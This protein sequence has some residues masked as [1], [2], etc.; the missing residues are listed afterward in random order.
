[1]PELPEVEV[2]RRSLEPRLVGHRIQRLEVLNRALR[3][4]VRPSD[5]RR[6]AVR[7]RIDAVG[8]RSKYL[9][10]ALERGATLVFHLGMSGRITLAGGGTP[11]ELHEHLRF[12]LDD[13][14]LL[15]FRDP[16]RFGLAFAL[17]S[18]QLAGD[19]HFATLGPEPLTDA[20][21]G[22]TLEAAA[23]RR[24]GPVKG[25]LMDAR[26]VVG[27]GNIYAC[28]ALHHSGIHPRRS[29]ARI[30]RSRWK[31]LAEAVKAVLARAIEEGGTTL[32]DFT[33][34]DG[35]SGYFQ[36][37]LAVYGRDGKA[38]ARCGRVIKRLVQGGRGTF[39]CPGCQR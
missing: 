10:I 6:L 15:R 8:R 33:D 5:L 18:D 37:S 31:S 35:R 32:N 16:R 26:V 19:R 2:L 25:F 36:V 4:P 1:M 34:G 13:G 23:S 29:V 28:E 20:F 7:R 14:R 11:P 24:R 9:L 27:V 17:P 3:E 22:A 39:Y 38:C 21:D 30:S 12:E